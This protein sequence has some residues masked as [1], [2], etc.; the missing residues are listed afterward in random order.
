MSPENSLK[1]FKMIH[2]A[3]EKDDQV[4]LN[5]LL[6]DLFNN[7][8]ENCRPVVY[9]VPVNWLRPLPSC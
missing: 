2:A 4:L 6:H 9:D 8:E 7:A 3:R 1:T 5:C